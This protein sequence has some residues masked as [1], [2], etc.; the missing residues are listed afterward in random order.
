MIGSH[1]EIG[2]RGSFEIGRPRSRG[3]N[4]FRRRMTRGVRGLKNWTIFMDVIYVSSLKLTVQI[5]L[6]LSPCN[7]F[8]INDHNMT[9]NSV[10][11]CFEVLNVKPEVKLR[12]K[13]IN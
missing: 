10:D 8:L 1:L 13:T 2:G 5:Q 6:A 3:W 12:F 9:S 11:K 4:N 7:P